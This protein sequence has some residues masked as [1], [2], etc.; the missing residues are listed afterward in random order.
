MVKNVGPE[1]GLPGFGIQLCL[2]LVVI[3]LCLRFP[4][5]KSGNDD[6]NISRGSQRFYQVQCA[7][8]VPDRECSQQQ[9]VIITYDMYRHTSVPGTHT[10]P[11]TQPH[12]LCLCKKEGTVYVGGDSGS[13]MGWLTP[14]PSWPAGLHPWVVQAVIAPWWSTCDFDQEPWLQ[15]LTSE[16]LASG[17]GLSAAVNGHKPGESP[18][19][20]QPCDS[21]QGSREVC[22]SWEQSG[23]GRRGEGHFCPGSA[24]P[25]GQ[26]L[27]LSI[28]A[29]WRCP[30][31]SQWQVLCRAWCREKPRVEATQPSS[32]VSGW[33]G[34][35]A[36][37]LGQGWQDHSKIPGPG[38]DPSRGNLRGF[39]GW[40]WGDQ[41]GEGLERT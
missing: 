26:W 18:P 34:S 4:H 17:R 11:H 40:A 28:F 1:A 20:A 2:F 38:Q 30:Q 39:G 3:R 23:G 32:A 6:D 12:T 5:L 10:Y 31:P 29:P 14:D 35:P 13:P 41:F 16:L 25:G 8:S 19:G 7:T 33:S 27:S 9:A 36:N 22:W 37:G 15:H 24:M 21:C